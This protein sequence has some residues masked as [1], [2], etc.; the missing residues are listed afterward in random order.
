M[1]VKKD[2]NRL[3]VQFL[4]FLEL[5]LTLAEQVSE[6]V[7]LLSALAKRHKELESRVSAIEERERHEATRRAFNREYS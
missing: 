6:I 7:D 5:S 4:R 1:R 2:L 3:R